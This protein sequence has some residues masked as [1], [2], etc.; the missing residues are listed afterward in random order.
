MSEK[1]GL[2]LLRE[3]FPDHQIGKLPKPTKKQTDEVKQ[4]FKKG[5]RCTECGGWHHPKVV[6]LD[7]VGH[8]AMTARFLE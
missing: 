2:E 3:P 4:D 7:Y 1:K 8:A 6:H 5:T